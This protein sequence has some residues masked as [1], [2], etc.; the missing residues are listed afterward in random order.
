M[1]RHG[2]RRTVTV[3]SDSARPLRPALAIVA[4]CLMAIAFAACGG[5]NG[6]GGNGG[7]Q[8]NPIFGTWR[9]ATNMGC[10]G[11]VSDEI[12]FKPDGTFSRLTTSSEVNCI[13]AS[14]MV[15]TTGNYEVDSTHG[16]INLTNIDTEPKQQCLPGGGC[17]TLATVTS[18]TLQYTMPDSN[19]LS[20]SCGPGCTI[21]YSKVG[22]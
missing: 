18:D 3:A 22:G 2:E 13:S 12:I 21:T 6:N 8:S 20:L 11:R 19:T 14:L 4:A 15:R 10:L 9:G 17:Q 5:G 1:R 7:G 16:V